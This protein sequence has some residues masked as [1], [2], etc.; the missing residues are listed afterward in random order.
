MPKRPLFLLPLLAVLLLARSGP[1]AAVPLGHGFTYQGQL[2][3]SGVPL[4]GTVSLSFRLW[5]APGTGTPPTGGSQIGDTQVIANVAVTG[6]IFSVVL[7]EGDQF[8]NSAFN[9]EARWLQI[10]IC[11]DSTCG[12]TTVLGPRQPITGAPYALGPWQLVGSN[13]NYMQGKVGIGTRTPA[14]PLH[15]KATGPALILEDMA[16][17]SQQA[18]YVAFW[19]PT[20]ETGW[21]GYGTPGSPVMTMA[22]ARA[23][24][25][26]ALWSSG[27][28][29]RVTST[30]NVGVGTSTP[31]SKLEVRGDVRLGPTGQ[32]FAPSSSENL[33]FIRGKVSSAGGVLFGSGFTASRT[34]VG[35]YSLTFSPTFPAGQF[36]IVTASAESNGTVA[37]F[38]MVNTPTNVAVVIRIVNGSGSAADTDFYFIAVGPR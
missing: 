32:Y 38:A 11:A 33:R 3:Q 37:R 7:N 31:A 25:D 27:E 15:V 29:L 23:G 30:G 4:D 35:V 28:R 10:E 24:G 2:Q 12:A 18:G 17:A 13:L 34:A 21:I 19:N 20:A 26:I 9:G 16:V 8:S 6:G 14:Y 22:N 36:P 1:A 5:D